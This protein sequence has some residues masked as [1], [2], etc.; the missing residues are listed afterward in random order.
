LIPA[1]FLIASLSGGSP[2]AGE[3]R[4][5][6]S[7]IIHVDAE[8]G[9]L[10]VS[11]DNAVIAVEAT[12]DA[13]PHLSKLPVG[14][15]IDIVVEMRPPQPPLLKTWKVAAGESACKAFDGKSCR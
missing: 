1:I 7:P 12:P 8:K 15:M 10:V 9:L 14:G 6:F 13:K 11:V 2:A 4:S 3:E 5:I